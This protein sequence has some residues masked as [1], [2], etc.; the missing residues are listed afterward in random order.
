MLTVLLETLRD[1]DPQYPPEELG[2]D[3]VVIR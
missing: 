1:L 2:L 3:G